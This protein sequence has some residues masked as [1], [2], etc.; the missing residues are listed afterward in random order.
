MQIHLTREELELATTWG[1]ARTEIMAAKG[2]KPGYA[3]VG[4]KHTAQDNDVLGVIAEVAACYLLGAD[5]HNPI[6]YTPVA[7]LDQYGNLP[8]ECYLPDILQRFEI[9][10][11]EHPATAIKMYQKDKDANATIIQAVVEHECV[12]GAV[13]PTGRVEFI[14]WV[15]AKE[16][17]DKAKEDR[18]GVKGTLLKNDMTMLSVATPRLVRA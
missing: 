2:D 5:P 13:V 9:R 16:R 3:K 7:Q 14:G 18:W 8:E 10:R 4:M 6:H 12:Y 11:V 15:K 17:F 1:K